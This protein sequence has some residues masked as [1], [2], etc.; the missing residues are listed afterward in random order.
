M[1]LFFAFVLAL[2]LALVLF[3]VLVFVLVAGERRGD[4][5]KAPVQRSRH[6]RHETPGEIHE[7]ELLQCIVDEYRIPVT[8]TYRY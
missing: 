8:H 5:E 2:A 6:A 1:L 7:V 4:D 3:L